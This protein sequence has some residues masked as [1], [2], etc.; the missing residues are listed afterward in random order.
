MGAV[1]RACLLPASA[2]LLLAWS[3]TT[4]IP[5]DGPGGAVRASVVA[6][7]AA[8]VPLVTLMAIAVIILAIRRRRWES[9]AAAA[10][11]ALLPWVFLIPY[12]GGD[13]PSREDAAGA[14]TLRVMVVNAHEGRASPTDVVAAV[15]GNAIDVLVVTELTG[16]LAHDLTAAG[17]DARVTARWI[18]VPG[19]DGVPTDPEAGMGIWTHATIAANQDVPGT[20]WP[21]TEVRLEQPAVTVIAAHVATP[22]PTGAARWSHDLMALRART[23]ASTGPT[24]LLGNL[25]AT[26][27]HADLRAFRA[28]GLR[29]AADALGQGPRPTWPA[30]SPFPLLPLD[31]VM[32]SPD[33]A[34]SSLGTVV[35]DGSDHRGLVAAV[36][37]PPEG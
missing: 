36:R 4:L 15:T 2:F 1:V 32:V 28:A 18:R 3:L 5:A 16:S 26:P 12:A 30:W 24:V 8:V 25:N 20:T 27:L 23:A 35:I 34:V 7:P 10:I 14:P 21:A 33:V 17:L 6:F 19:Q 31:H 29:D 11:A 22:T 37:L 9:V 13:Q